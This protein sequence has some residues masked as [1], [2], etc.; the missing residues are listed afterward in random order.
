V[1]TLVSLLIVLIVALVILVSFPNAA[2]ADGNPCG[3]AGCKPMP[4]TTLS[5]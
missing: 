1:K 2:R 3:G 5:Q 4:P